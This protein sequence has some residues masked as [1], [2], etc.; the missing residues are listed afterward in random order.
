M[1]KDSYRLEIVTM[2]LARDLLSSSSTIPTSMDSFSKASS[3]SVPMASRNPSMVPSIESGLSDSP[4]FLSITPSKVPSVL[5]T[6]FPTPSPSVNPS[7]AP[8]LEEESITTTTLLQGFTVSNGRIFDEIEQV[9]FQDVM[10]SYA[11]EIVDYP[12][13]LERINI[14]CTIKLQR[15]LVDPERRRSNRLLE[16]LILSTNA[17]NQVEYV[18][19][20]SS[21]Y[22][23]V[24]GYPSEFTDIIDTNRNGLT[25]RLEAFGLS[26]LSTL[27]LRTVVTTEIPSTA[28]TSSYSPTR[29]KPDKIPTKNPRTPVTT[30]PSI[31]SLTSN[32]DLSQAQPTP[33]GQ[34]NSRIFSIVLA[35]LISLLVIAFIGV[36]LFFALRRRKAKKMAFHTSVVS[37]QLPNEISSQV[38]F[39]HPTDKTYPEAV[40]TNLLD[41]RIYDIDDVISPEKSLVT[42]QSLLSPAIFMGEETID[43][44]DRTHHLADEF[45]KYKDQN[46]EKVRADV[47]DLVIGSDSMMNQAMVLAFMGN[48]EA[49]TE[50]LDAGKDG[51]IDSTEIETSALCEVHD[52]LKRNEDADVEDR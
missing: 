28:P 2:T 8:T 20:W 36:C 30:M 50:T 6:S 33:N 16:E 10:I 32:P 26:V 25:A 4:T 29:I 37:D 52:F 5:P 7:I 11:Q 18:M 45:D 14:N 40:S 9:Y 31:I 27:P 17:T 35:S 12:S 21:I 46:L 1:M 44:A 43:E 22:I 34:S 41:L 39:T 13:T 47:Q 49:I 24:T 3:S 42:S 19:E 23:D 15:L 48:E 51:K 38:N